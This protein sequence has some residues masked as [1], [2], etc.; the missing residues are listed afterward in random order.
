MTTI[1]TPGGPHKHP[2][3]EARYQE[4]EPAMVAETSEGAQEMG[5]RSSTKSE[6]LTKEFGAALRLP[7]G[8]ELDPGDINIE[9]S[10]DQTMI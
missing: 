4:A 2:D 7:E 8:I 3:E 9:T 5:P 10:E 6:E 1:H